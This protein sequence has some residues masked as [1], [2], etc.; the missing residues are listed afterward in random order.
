MNRD[1]LIP[2]DQA[3]WD[4]TRGGPPSRNG[5]K[6]TAD[7]NG[8]PIPTCF[9]DSEVGEAFGQT[10]RGRY[11]YCSPLGGWM[12]WDGRRWRRDQ[13]EGVFEE[14]RLYVLALGHALLE[15]N[16]DRASIAHAVRYRDRGKLDAIV[17]IARRLDGIAATS[18]EFDRHPDRLVARN[19]VVDLRTGQLGEHDPALR[20]TK[21]T[22]VDYVP[23]ALHPDVDAV[24]ATMTDGVRGWMQ[25]LAGYAATDHVNE[26]VMPVLDGSGSNGK[27]SLLGAFRAA[28]GDY[29]CVADARLLMKSAHDEHPTLFAD[30]HGRRLVSVEET[31]EGGSMRVESM[32]FLTGGSTIKA[33]FIRADYFEFE[34]KHTLVVATNHRPAVNSTEHATWRR[35]RLIPFPYRYEHPDRMRPG[36]RL[37]D[38]KL[39]DRLRYGRAQRQAML[40]WIVAGAVA[41]HRDGL[42]DCPEVHDATEAWRRSEDVILRYCHDRIEFDVNGSIGSQALYDDFRRWCEDEGRPPKSNK[43]L[44]M[45]LRE[46]DIF[47]E[48]GIEWGRTMIGA[49]WFGLAFRECS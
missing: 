47:T 38:P 37:I 30:L 36:D 22:N 28:L 33:R 41:W 34:P 20:I 5:D 24:L 16:G 10:L 17:T 1:E 19:G 27:T 2:D 13:T 31:A 14:A 12:R 18:D 29:A 15:S 6:P 40:A 23:D 26:D 49:R 25:R 42:G 21:C 32:K 46:H 48:N 11:L 35:L 39:R 3:V 7:T 9:S 43:A 45:Q 4:A 8:V 44:T